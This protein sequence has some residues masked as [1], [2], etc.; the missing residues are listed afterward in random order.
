MLFSVLLFASL[1]LLSVGV[2]SA[3]EPP[4]PQQQEPVEEAGGV[5]SADDSATAAPPA[6]SV[7]PAT[8]SETDATTT[9]GTSRRSADTKMLKVE[10]LRKATEKEEA[11]INA[12]SKTE[13]KIDTLSKTEAPLHTD[14]SVGGAARALLQHNSKPGPAQQIAL[15]REGTRERMQGRLTQLFEKTR[16]DQAA[17]KRAKELLG[18]AFEN[19]KQHKLPAK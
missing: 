7:D 14:S 15:L 13:A 19:K 5:V 2:S 16:N 11:K 12:L 10:K 8:E 9:E 1:L 17:R 4:P 18:K 3:Q 6:M